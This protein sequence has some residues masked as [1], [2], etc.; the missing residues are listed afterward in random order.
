R[1]SP[2][3]PLPSTTPFR[4]TT[5]FNGAIVITGALT[6]TNAA[7]GATTFA[8][9]VSVGSA[10][11]RGTTFDVQNSF[12]TGAA[13]ALAVTNSGLFTKEAIGTAP[14]RTA[15]TLYAH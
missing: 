13:G 14:A 10:T 4:S 3:T 8:A 6:Q 7:T 1:P 11:L 12:T 15:F 2:P 9:G 5:N